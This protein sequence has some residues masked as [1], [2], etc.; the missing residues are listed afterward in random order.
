[1]SDFAR[2]GRQHKSTQ[3]RAVRRLL[4]SGE[5]ADA[6]QLFGQSCLFC[7]G[8]CHSKPGTQLL[9]LHS[10]R[11]PPCDFTRS[12][13]TTHR[14]RQKRGKIPETTFRDPLAGK[15]SSPPERVFAFVN[16]I[17]HP[18]C[19]QPETIG[20]AKPIGCCVA[21]QRSPS[22]EKCSLYGSERLSS[23][24]QIGVSDVRG[25]I[26]LRLRL[27]SRLRLRMRLRLRLRL[28][29]SG[30]V[31]HLLPGLLGSSDIAIQLGIANLVEP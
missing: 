11:P 13:N 5:R 8:L 20:T 17:S 28:R 16:L 18:P 14:S 15:K 26:R 24:E 27:R 22:P 6:V 10:A 2:T 29:L 30:P 19:P 31:Q 4:E 23:G 25:S 7:F 9:Q 12:F 3:A 21:G 1:M